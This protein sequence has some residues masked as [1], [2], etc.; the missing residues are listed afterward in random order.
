MDLV[1]TSAFDSFFLLTGGWVFLLDYP[2]FQCLVTKKPLAGAA[3]GETP[4]D[5]EG[6]TC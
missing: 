6:G 3:L 1:T 5:F 2:W 4:S